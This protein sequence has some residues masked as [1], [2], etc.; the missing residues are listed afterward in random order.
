MS[1]RQRSALEDS[2]LPE[3][4]WAHLLLFLKHFSQTDSW[5]LVVGSL[6]C[7]LQPDGFTGVKMGQKMDLLPR[8]QAFIHHPS[9]R[10]SGLSAISLS[11]SHPS[12]SVPWSLALL[13]HLASS[14]LPD[15]CSTLFAIL[16]VP[17]VKEVWLPTVCRHSLFQTRVRHPGTGCMPGSSGPPGRPLLWCTNGAEAA[18]LPARVHH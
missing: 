11:A 5:V 2:P 14:L 7:G 3:G 10:P 6:I 9:H 1:R 16:L 4:W 18:A 17:V 8:T 13:T 12:V 15:L